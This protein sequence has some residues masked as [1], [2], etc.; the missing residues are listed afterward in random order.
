MQATSQLFFSPL[1][2][3]R[4]SV[5]GVLNSIEAHW[6][7]QPSAGSSWQNGNRHFCCWNMKHLNISQKIWDIYIEIL[8]IFH[9]FHILL[10]ASGLWLTL[11]F[12]FSPAQ[13]PFHLGS[14][15][16]PAHWATKRCLSEG[17]GDLMTLFLMKIHENPYLNWNFINLRLK[18]QSRII[19]VMKYDHLMIEGKISAKIS[20]GSPTLHPAGSNVLRPNWSTC[21]KLCLLNDGW[22]RGC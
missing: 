21:R 19:K 22:I 3:A 9:M 13:F 2:T 6:K 20:L 15:P 7:G 11:T 14:L 18:K 8:W 10:E 4:F 16:L 1:A 17:S 5:Q 12:L